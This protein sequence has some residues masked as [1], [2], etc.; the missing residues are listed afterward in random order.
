MGFLLGCSWQAGPAAPLRLPTADVECLPA[1]ARGSVRKHTQ[2][3]STGTA[4]PQAFGVRQRTDRGRRQSHHERGSSTLSS[5]SQSSVDRP[6]RHCCGLSYLM[7]STMNINTRKVFL[8]LLTCA[9]A[10]SLSACNTVK[11]LGKDTERAGEKIQKEA[12]RHDDD[13]RAVEPMPL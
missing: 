11:G 2:G 5:L 3:R 6:E 13:N 7:E 9:F 8:L 4:E 1:G 12:G 10:F